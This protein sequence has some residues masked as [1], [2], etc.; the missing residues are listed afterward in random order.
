MQNSLARVCKL[1]S[2]VSYSDFRAQFL[3]NPWLNALGTKAC[4]RT[5]NVGTQLYEIAGNVK[6]FMINYKFKLLNKV[7]NNKVTKKRY[8]L[9]VT[10]SYFHKQ[11]RCFVHMQLC[12]HSNF[13]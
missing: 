1:E 11:R 5:L 7:R 3:F 6:I 12:E 9:L 2:V 8:N 10:K 13:I 4:Q